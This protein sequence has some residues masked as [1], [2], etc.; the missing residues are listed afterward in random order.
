[1]LLVGQ[2]GI[3]FIYFSSFVGVVELSPLTDLIEINDRLRIEL[4]GFPLD[5]NHMRSNY[6]KR[7]RE[8]PHLFPDGCPINSCGDATTRYDSLLPQLVTFT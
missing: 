8:R 5:T 3:F 7:E 2:F 6:A 4:Y 1:M